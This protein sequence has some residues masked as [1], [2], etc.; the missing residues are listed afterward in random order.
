[1]CGSDQDPTVFFQNTEIMA[2]EWTPY[3]QGGLVS[4]LDLNGTP[5]GPYAL[6]QGAFQATIAQLEAAQGA[7]AIASYHATEAPF[8]M[9][10]ARGFFAAVP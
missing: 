8:C 4:T 5:S 1:M 3:V 7:S 9:A 10:A 6:L 2:A